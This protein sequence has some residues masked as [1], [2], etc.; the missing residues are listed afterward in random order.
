[1]N[2]PVIELSTTPIDDGQ[3]IV[4]PWPCSIEDLRRSIDETL[5]DS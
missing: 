4:V 2:L 5:R 1:M 3:S